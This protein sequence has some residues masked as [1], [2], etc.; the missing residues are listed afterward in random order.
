MIRLVT[1]FSV[2]IALAPI[3]SQATTFKIAT[4]SPDGSYWMQAMRAG[5]KEIETL[6]NKRVRFKFYPG[7][8]MGNDK[9]VMRKIRIRQLQGGAVT[10]GAISTLYSDGQVY[11]LPMLFNDLNEISY[12]RNKLDNTIISGLEKKGFVSFGLAEGGFAYI[13]STHPVLDVAALRRYKTWIPSSDSLIVEAIKAYDVQPVALPVGDVLTGLQ[14]G[15][16][17]TVASPPIATLALHWHTQV[18]YFT[19]MPLL[20]S[21]ALLV[22]DKRAFHKISPQDQKTVRKVMGKVFRDIDSRNRQD[23]NNAYTALKNQG[24][25]FVSPTPSQLSEWRNYATRARKEL[26]RSGFISNS[27]MSRV[28]ALL[29]EYRKQH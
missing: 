29:T 1:L 21:Y 12:V 20:Y 14:T 25:E 19:D 5:A 4:L 6:T 22:V 13:M 28:D 10:A 16:I 24:I 8:V 9:A 26:L 7:G 2:L 3:S 23:N 17:D 11:N 27:M 15:L 18:K